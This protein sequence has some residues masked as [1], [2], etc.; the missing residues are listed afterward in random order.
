MSPAQPGPSPVLPSSAPDRVS[1]GTASR[2]LAGCAWLFCS[3]YFSGC[4]APGLPQPP[5][6]PIPEAIADLTARQMGDGALL[7]FTLP[8]KTVTG[9]RLRESPACEIFRGAMKPDGSADEKSFRMV[10][11]IPGALVA[12]YILDKHVVFLDPIPPQESRAQSDGKMAYVV[13]TRISQK[14]SSANSNIVALTVFPVAQRIAAVAAQVTESAVELS[15]AAPTQTSGGDPLGDFTYRVYRGQLANA[16]GAAGANA[17]GT[18][19]PGADAPA[20]DAAS[21]DLL[22][23]KW[24]VK[25]ALVGS[26]ASNNFRDTDFAFDQTYVYVVRTATPAN[27]GILESADSA[28]AVVAPKDIFPPAAPQ[29]LVA[30]VV[31]DNA[32]APAV[33]DLSWS[34]SPESDVAGYRVYRSEQE[35]TRGES[36]PLELAPT[37]AVRDAGVQAG[38]HYWYRVTAVDRAGNESAASAAVMV[39]IP[40]A[41]T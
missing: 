23:A 31:T 19:A 38:R 26:P 32:A 4:G 6:P 39:E 37:P 2:L 36:L 30:A 13:R 29:G 40:P 41:G 5:S 1:W 18:G 11:T 24:K 10:Y 21:K 15:W 27:G 28:P 8:G 35:T 3:L 33:V 14:K 25:L 16:P 34:I 17:A 22:H 7:T 20:M 12:D 9:Q